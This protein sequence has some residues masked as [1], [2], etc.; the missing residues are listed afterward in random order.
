MHSDRLLADE[1]MA[2]HPIDV[3]RILERL[4][5]LDTVACLQD[6]SPIIAANVLTVMTPLSATPC[7]ERL[8]VASATAIMVHLPIDTATIIL[9]RMEAT[10]RTAL[11]EA[12]PRAL[13]GALRRVLQY[14]EGTAGALMDPRVCTIPEDMTVEQVLTY[15]RQYARLLSDYVYVVNREHRLVGCVHLR[16][17]AAGTAPRSYYGHHAARQ[18]WARSHHEP[19]GYRDASA[20]AAGVGAASAG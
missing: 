20:V 19:F 6:V 3:A 5:A 7:L 9:R 10:P 11:L 18:R 14:P 17:I 1:F 12:L 15:L 13:A 2:T 4:P 16:P 8:D